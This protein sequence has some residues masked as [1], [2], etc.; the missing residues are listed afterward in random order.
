MLLP[1]VGRD[2]GYIPVRSYVLERGAANCWQ[3]TLLEDGEAIGGAVGSEGDYEE[4][5]GVAEEFCETG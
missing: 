5:L 1:I 4:L 3:L 2:R